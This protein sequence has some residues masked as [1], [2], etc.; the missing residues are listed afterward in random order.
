MDRC[1]IMWRKHEYE[2]TNEKIW[3]I[4]MYYDLTKHP[5][6]ARKSKQNFETHARLEI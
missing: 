4:K 6:D 3:G 2:G 1:A 5:V